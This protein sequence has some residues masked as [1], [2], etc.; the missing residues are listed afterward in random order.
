MSST[1][2]D[3]LYFAWLRERVGTDRER[4]ALPDDVRTPADLMTHLA[5]RSEGHAHAF[6]NPDVVR[7]AV[8]KKVADAALPFGAAREIAFFPP[9]TGG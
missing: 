1:E 2:V 3:L 9:M 8:D 5:A 6:E 7:V 4:I